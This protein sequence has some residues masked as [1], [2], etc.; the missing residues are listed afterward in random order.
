MTEFARTQYN[1]NNRIILNDVTTDTTKYILTGVPTASDTDV[2]NTEDEKPEEVGIIDYGSKLGRGVFVFPITL[3]AATTAKMNE[4]IQT[5]KQALNPDLLETDATYGEDTKYYG[6][7]PL[8]WSETVGETSRAFRVFAKPKEIPQVATDALSG[9]IRKTTLEFKI[10]D[11]RKYLQ[12]QSTL[13][14]AGTAN[15]AGTYTTPV[16]I[17]VTASGATST[18]LTITNSTTSESIYV[19]TALSAGQVLVIDTGAHSV[20]LNGTE[21]RSMLSG[22]S[23]WWLL[24]PG[25][26]TLALSNDSNTSVSFAWYSAWPL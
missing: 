13:S 26:N 18:S 8:E 12:T 1:F 24:N 16:V 6:Y 4:L 3:F 10:A 5:L 19:T 2:L 17:T 22:T 7:H 23:K 21:T 9:N 15:N 14:G 20:K 11:P 25:N